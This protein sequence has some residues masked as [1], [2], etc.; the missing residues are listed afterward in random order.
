MNR[1]IRRP[2]RN[3]IKALINQRPSITFRPLTSFWEKPKA[4]MNRYIDEIIT[5][6][7]NISILDQP[8][9]KSVNHL[10]QDESENEPPQPFGGC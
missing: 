1:K 4:K 10:K 5:L 3:E 6:T 7:L 8:P 9:V 2:E